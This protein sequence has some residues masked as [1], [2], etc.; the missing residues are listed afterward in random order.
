M[1]ASIKRI[2]YTFF[3]F[4]A[5]GTLFFFFPYRIGSN[6]SLYLKIAEL[7]MAG[8]R[9]YV[10]VLDFNPPL[11]YYL[12]CIPIAL[13]RFLGLEYV[14]A[15]VLPVFLL[16]WFCAARTFKLTQ[17]AS[18]ECSL[19]ILPLLLV[20]TKGYGDRDHLFA[21]TLMPYIFLR[22]RKLNSQ[23]VSGG[24]WLGGL[25][26]LMAALKPYFILQVILLESYF[27]FKTRKLKQLLQPE[28]VAVFS[29]QVLYVAHFFLLT[30]EI[31]QAF[32]FEIVPMTIAGYS[33]MGKTAWGLFESARIFLAQLLAVAAL[34]YWRWGSLG[35]KEKDVCHV[36]F[37]AA[38]AGFSGFLLQ[39][40]GWDYHLIPARYPL[41]ALLFYLASGTSM[42]W[43]KRILSVIC[44]V[45]FLIP[46]WRPTEAMLGFS[47]PQNSFWDTYRFVDR[48]MSTY[49]KQ[50]DR[51]AIFSPTT[52][53]YYPPILLRGY[54]LGTRY[55]TYYP[56]AFFNNR[57]LTDQTRPYPY[58]TYSVMPTDEKIFIDRI[59]EDVAT[60]KPMLLVFP[61][62]Q[63]ETYLPGNFNVFKY[64]ETAGLWAEWQDRYELVETDNDVLVYRRRT[65]STDNKSN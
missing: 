20:S 2:T 28:V 27:I 1:P 58:K 15:F 41:F 12:S 10:D 4:A 31:R 29:L 18:L 56:L 62:V 52:M 3:G 21:V 13:H 54:E 49:L 6:Q 43:R 9:P 59:R 8:A 32:F 61:I 57:Y 33:S 39:F 23:T 25:C 47:V 50:G 65:I 35:S 34:A 19:F 42:N 22:L 45:L 11:I 51:I 26:G 30:R 48:N 60:N 7:M 38:L 46:G 64:F 14:P 16:I 40:K 53:F 24:T 55:S 63:T 5:L 37:V 17:A 44:A 36:L